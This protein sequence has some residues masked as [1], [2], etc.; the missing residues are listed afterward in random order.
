[1]ILYGIPNCDTVRKARKFLEKNQIDY[2]FH[3]F[4]KKGLSLSLIQIWLTQHPIEKL[5]NKR[6]TTWKQLSDIQKEQLMSQT[7]IALLTEYPTLIKRPVLQIDRAPQPTIM[8][9]FDE[10]AYQILIH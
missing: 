2:Q 9:G 6:S 4:K 7:N 8:I 3:D 1:M 5:V 10:K